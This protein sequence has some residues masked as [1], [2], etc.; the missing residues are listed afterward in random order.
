M[1]EATRLQLSRIAP[2]V[3]VVMG[4]VFLV[5]GAAKSWDPVLF[6]WE[7]VSYWELLGV[8]FENWA[9]FARPTLV[10]GP[11]ECAVGV[12]LILNWRP[13]LALSA[14]LG[15]ML[16]FIGLTGHAWY[17][18]ADV[19][20]GCFGALVDRTP[21]EALVED[22]VMLG[23][24]LF[25]W[26]WG[27]AKVPPNMARWVGA[28]AAAALLLTGARFYPEIERVENSDLAG[29]VRLTGVG[30]DGSDLDLGDGDYLIVLFSPKCGHCK[31]AVPRLNEWADAPDLPTVVG[32]QSF[33]QESDA[34]RSFKD[35]MRPRFETATISNSDWKR[36]T[37]R[38]GFPRM[39]FVRDGVVQRVWERN[40]MPTVKQL[41][42]ITAADVADRSKA[43]G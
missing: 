7:A 29:G 19:N 34:L 26:K 11:M 20:C 42:T 12:A 40:E 10:L 23:A 36:L 17:Q 31:R 38:H 41:T 21:G 22:L 4:L 24:L 8:S 15:L 13:R 43:G 14:G 18:E 9:G 16:L 6:Y 3:R 1:N 33:S 25:A 30:L 28:T 27:I 2:Y 39:A 32:L 5:A 35:S 37:W